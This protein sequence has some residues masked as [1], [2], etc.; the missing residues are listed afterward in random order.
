MKQRHWQLCKLLCTVMHCTVLCE[1]NPAHLQILGGLLDLAGKCQCIPP[2]HAVMQQRNKEADAL[3][4]GAHI[5]YRFSRW[6]AATESPLHIWEGK[7]SA[8]LSN[9]SRSLWCW[10]QGRDPRSVPFSNCKLRTATAELPQWS[11]PARGHGT[12]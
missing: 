2:S 1:K 5:S 12:R 3:L 6:E 8:G 7:A 10:Q 9:S 4:S 11:L